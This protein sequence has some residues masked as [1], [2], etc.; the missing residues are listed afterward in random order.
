MKAI[1]AHL[2]D[3]IDRLMTALQT[4][5]ELKALQMYY[6]GQ[7][8]IMTETEKDDLLRVSGEYGRFP[9]A[10]LGVPKGTTISGMASVAQKKAN[11]W[12]AKASNGWMM[13]G[14]YIEVATIAARSYELIHY[15]LS[16]LV[17]E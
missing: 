3:E 11:H 8:E 9:E 12:N 6:S 14:T 13:P 16:A 1:A 7:L 5:K 17:E 15:H 2:K 10:R 4:L